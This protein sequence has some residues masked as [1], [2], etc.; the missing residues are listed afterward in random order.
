M[1]EDHK[2]VIGVDLDLD[3]LVFENHREFVDEDSV[4]ILFKYCPLC[5]RKSKKVN[6]EQ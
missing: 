1:N 6:H 4:V 3:I 5:G 2:H